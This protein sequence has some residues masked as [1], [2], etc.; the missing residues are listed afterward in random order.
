M[1]NVVTVHWKSDKWIDPQ[2]AYLERNIDEPYRV[3]AAL[4]GVDRRH[5][6]RFHFAA[7]LDGDH[8][9]KLNALAKI[10]MA[11]S[12]P[13]DILVFI[14]GDALPV[15]PIAAWMTDALSLVPAGGRAA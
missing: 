11:E 14:D 12:D 6:G 5:W 15:R 9:Q 1:I 4:R 8:P 3:F 7:D 2:L 10:V 13:D